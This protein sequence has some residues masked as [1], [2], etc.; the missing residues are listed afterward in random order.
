MTLIKVIISPYIEYKIISMEMLFESFTYW[1]ILGLLLVIIELF[2]MV[3]F[4]ALD[5][6]IGHHPEHCGIS[7]SATLFRDTACGFCFAFRCHLLCGDKVFPCKNGR[8][9]DKSQS[10]R[11]HWQGVHSCVYW[12]RCYQ[13]A[14]GRV[15]VVCK[16]FRYERWSKSSGHRYRRFNA[17]RWTSPRKLRTSQHRGRTV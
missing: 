15:V 9:R 13:S 12:Q 2:F 17:N 7:L 10:Y 6:S 5:W 8:W 1:L 14:A 3:N 4:L 16:G 11:P